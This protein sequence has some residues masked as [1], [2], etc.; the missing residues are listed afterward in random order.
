MRTAIIGAG[1]LGIIIGGLM[2]RSGQDVELV[3]PH[4]ASAEAFNRDGAVIEGAVEATIPVKAVTPAGMTGAYDCAL[5][6]TKLD[7]TEQALREL[8]PHLGAESLVCTLQNGMPEEM[9]ARA[10]GE[11]RTAGGIVLMCAMRTA[12]NV[13]RLTSNAQVLRRAFE[14]GELHGRSTPRIQALANALSAVGGCAVVPNLL[15][16][17]WAK[18]LLNTAIGAMTAVF[19]C[20]SSTVLATPEA[21][22]FTVRTADETIR[23]AHACGRRL[24]VLGGLDLERLALA[25]GEAPEAKFGFFREYFGPYGDS[26]SSMLQDLEHGR[27][28]EVRHLNGYVSGKGRELG[29]PTPCNDL[30][31]R[32]VAEAEAKGRAPLMAES[33]AAVRALPRG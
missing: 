8:A 13:S 30:V 31:V 32:L 17:R 2:A 4:E 33:L 10:V 1:S 21:L 6:L 26:K 3:V 18:L 29:L 20:P 24:A 23:L 22:D 14:I 11:E 5:L 9:V 27:R 19:G 25:Q 16:I 15:E 7:A 12:P 28:T